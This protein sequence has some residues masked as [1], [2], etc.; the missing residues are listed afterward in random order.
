MIPASGM[1]INRCSP[2][3]NARRALR[4]S[5]ILWSMRR[6]LGVARGQRDHLPP[7]RFYSHRVQQVRRPDVFLSP[8]HI[9]CDDVFRLDQDYFVNTFVSFA[10]GSCEEAA[11]LKNVMK[12]YHEGKKVGRFASRYP[13][14]PLVLHRAAY[15]LISRQERSKAKMVELTIML[16]A[17]DET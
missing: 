10:R 4:P 5:K 17:D 13:C 1:T 15:D 14:R 3:P 16:K 9:V 2:A 6:G 11:A 7:E 12:K 8:V